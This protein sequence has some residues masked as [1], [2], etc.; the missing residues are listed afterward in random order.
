[1][2]ESADFK[3]TTI[4]KYERPND[5][6]F[7]F[8]LSFWDTWDLELIHSE[9]VPFIDEDGFPDHK[10]KNIFRVVIFELNNDESKEIIKN[11]KNKAKLNDCEIEI[12]NLIGYHSDKELI[13]I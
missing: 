12:I 4:T 6:L 9:K 13:K 7:Y 11:V 5:E 8:L 1:M 2:S 10:T 3:I